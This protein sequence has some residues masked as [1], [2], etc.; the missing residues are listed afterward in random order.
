MAIIYQGNDKYKR[1]ECGQV[2]FKIRTDGA[3]LIDIASV[4]NCDTDYPDSYSIEIYLSLPADVLSVDVHITGELYDTD[5]YTTT[6]NSSLTDVQEGW[7]SRFET[8]GACALTGGELELA[9]SPRGA[10]ASKYKSGS[11]FIRV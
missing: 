9:I 4:C 1:V 6:I 2:R 3:D 10:D 8:V 5:D 11:L 7:I